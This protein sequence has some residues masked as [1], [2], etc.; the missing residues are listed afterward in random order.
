MA[1]DCLGIE[2]RPTNLFEVYFEDTADNTIIIKEIFNIYETLYS[3]SNMVHENWNAN[4]EAS[5]QPVKVGDFVQV[6]AEFHPADQ[7]VKHNIIIHPRMSFGTG[8]HATTYL[9]MEEMQFLELPNKTVQDYGCGTGILSILAEMKGASKVLATDNDPQ[10]IINTGE[11]ILLNSCSRIESRLA[12]VPDVGFVVD[13]MLANINK[14]I[15]LQNMDTIIKATK[16][17]GKVILSGLLEAD[18]DDMIHALN[19]HHIKN[20]ETSTRD[21]WLKISFHI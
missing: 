19:S 13:I 3:I 11:N 21:G 1:G 2:E 6:R 16:Q 20:I 10:C 5:F 9:M 14:N 17:E 12:A 8:H 7:N 15:L 4:W 18:L